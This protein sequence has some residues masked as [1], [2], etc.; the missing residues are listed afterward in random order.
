MIPQ[1]AHT[2]RRAHERFPLGSQAE[3]A[4]SRSA[5]ITSIV[6]DLSSRGAGII[7]TVPFDLGERVSLTLK[8][9]FLFRQPIARRAIIVWCHKLDRDLW[10][11]GVDFGSDNLVD[12]S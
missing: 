2:Y 6:S 8:P 5:N 7:S 9:C 3:I 10:Q 12:L 4:T 11:A 1:T